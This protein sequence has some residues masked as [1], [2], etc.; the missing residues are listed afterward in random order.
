MRH[1]RI[2]TAAALFALVGGALHA[3]QPGPADDPPED[4][5][6]QDLG[7][8]V[9]LIRGRANATFVVGRDGVVLIDTMTA[10]H[11]EIIRRSIAAVTPLPI[12]YVIDT[13]FH[14]DHVGS[15]GEFGRLGIPIVAQR[16]TVRRLSVTT[17]DVRGV[18]HP[19][20]D[21]TALPGIA[22]D[23]RRRLDIPG[24]RIELVHLR[25][26]HT[27]GDC[28]VWLPRQNVL[29]SGDVFKTAEHPFFDAGNGG[30]LAG[31]IAANRQLLARANDATTL[32]PGHGP[33]GSRSQLRASLA[34]MVRTREQVRRLV[35]QGR[36][37]EQVLAAGLL[38]DDASVQPG[39]PDFRDLFVGAVYDSE[40][41]T[42]ARVHA[43]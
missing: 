32:V 10:G 13:H 18:V 27:D 12:R 24:V 29:L 42:A 39:G 28:Y 38:R 2:A 1:F 35:G 22:F 4:I 9:Y 16:G 19:P 8:G 25:S 41:A 17:T 15:N 34:M 36:S 40:V 26:A 11:G 37:R 33:P 30:T 6:T 3:A 7:N 31:T 20:A 21:A 23:E 43:R 14:G 5:R